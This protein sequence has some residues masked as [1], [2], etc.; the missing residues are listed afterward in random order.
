MVMLD[1]QVSPKSNLLVSY[2]ICHH[3]R[4]GIAGC[5]KFL[6]SS[7][8]RST[9]EGEVKIFRNLEQPLYKIDRKQIDETYVPLHAED[10]DHLYEYGAVW[11]FLDTLEERIK[12]DDWQWVI[13]ADPSSLA[14]RSLDHLLPDVS[15]AANNKY[16]APEFDFMFTPQS[17][18]IEGQIRNEISTGL[19]AVRGEHFG[20]VMEHWKKI[21]ISHQSNSI[22]RDAEIWSQVVKELPLRKKA[23]EKDEV[24][25]PQ[26]HALDWEKIANAAFIT[27]PDWPQALQS[28]FIQALYFGTF[29]ADKT[30]LMINILE[31]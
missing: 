9:F 18:K 6:T 22:I 4:F 31:V 28:K 1:K 19:W 14:M 26:L 8:L 3:E 7:L 25:A 29:Y 20:L 15:I 21:W 10:R 12:P 16:P 11:E 13:V 24:V 27:I 2:E 30:G 5:C 23:F 17:R